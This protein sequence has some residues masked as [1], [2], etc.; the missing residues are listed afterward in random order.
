MHVVRNWHSPLLREAM[1]HVDRSVAG[2]T[3]SDVTWHPDGK[4]SSAEIVE[5]LSL[6][7]LVTVKAGRAVLRHRLPEI[8]PPALW[9]KIMVAI[10]LGLGRF[11]V[12]LRAPRM[13]NPRGLG[14]QEARQAMVQNLI[15]MDEV[16]AQCAQKL[17]AQRPF[18]PH[19][20]LGPLTVEQW[21]KFHLIHT[22]HHMR[23]VRALRRALNNAVLAGKRNEY[24]RAPYV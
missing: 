13:V 14:W 11:F 15:D 23:Q 3:E 22:R 1:L 10:A 4:W 18:L 20:V 24:S 19:P 2:M 9:E 7:L 6:A 5:H 16:L 17:G 21:R 12:R 8:G